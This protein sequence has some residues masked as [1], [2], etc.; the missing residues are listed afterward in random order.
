MSLEVVLG[1]V[2]TMS[3]TFYALLG[4]ADYGAGIWYL[5]SSGRRAQ[6]QRKV[7]IAALGP[8]WET[9]HVWLILALTVLFSAFSKAFS[10]ISTV[11]HIPLTMLLVGIVMRGSA[12]AFRTGDVKKDEMHLWWDRIFAGSSLLTPFFLGV[13]IGAIASGQLTLQPELFV[14]TFVTPWLA[15]FPFS[16]GALTVALFAF[17]AA[18]YLTLETQDQDLRED[19]RR[20]ALAAAIAVWLCCGIVFVCASSGAPHLYRTMTQSAWQGSLFLAVGAMGA[21]ALVALWNRW[22]VVARVAAAG[23]LIAIIWGWVLAQF[24]YLIEPD[25]TVYDAAAPLRTLQLLCLIFLVGGCL[26]LPA[27]FYLFRVFKGGILSSAAEP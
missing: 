8:I 4:G 20:R 26:V 11:L 24:P 18:V 13:T 6:A 9:N 7:I 21:T 5:L 15:P 19:F 27:L 17:L 10:M 23:E 1:G 14:E 3:L 25:V 22:Y 12:F 16:V 2:M